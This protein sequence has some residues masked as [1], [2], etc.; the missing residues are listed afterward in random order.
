MV[1]IPLS[2]CEK[3]LYGNKQTKNKHTEGKKS[4]KKIAENKDTGKK[5]KSKQL[6]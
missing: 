2:D 1:L 4:A 3:T 6:T 5:L